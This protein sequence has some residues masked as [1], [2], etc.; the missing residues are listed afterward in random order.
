[1]GYRTPNFVEL[2]RANG[3]P[4]TVNEEFAQ[5]IASG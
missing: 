4:Y 5:R 3:L 2:A 1:M